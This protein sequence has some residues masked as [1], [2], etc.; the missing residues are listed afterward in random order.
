MSEGTSEGMSPP[1]A[2]QKPWTRR[3]H[4]DDVADPY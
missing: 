3:H 4:G 2:A 1:V